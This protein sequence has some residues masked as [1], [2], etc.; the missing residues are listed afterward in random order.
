MN[1]FFLDENPDKCAEYHVD[2]HCI[3]QILEATQVLCSV[4]P[5]GTAP[6]RRTHYNHPCSIW[7][8]TNLS[9][10]KK[11]IT[12]A[13]AL[14]KEYTYRYGKTHKSSL[15][16]NWIENNMPK[17]PEGDSTEPPRCFGA[18]KDTIKTTN[19]VYNDYRLYYKLG[20][21]NL[22]SWKNRRKPDW[23]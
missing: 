21:S 8:R 23:I 19:S 20:K 22:F 4:Y 3:K 12:Y 15:V 10:Y 1:L 11:T 13:R 17:L 2:K 7:S 9:N 5:Q 6:Y 16:L 14:C 18:L